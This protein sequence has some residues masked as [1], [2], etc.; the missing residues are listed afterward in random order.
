[1]RS[2]T[3]IG[4]RSRAR[5]LRRLSTVSRVLVVGA[6]ALTVTAVVSG[7]DGA[8]ARDHDADGHQHVTAG[9]D[10]R[11]L[12]ADPTL[13]RTG[14]TA[15]ADSLESGYGAGAVLDGNANSI[16]H[17]QYSGTIAPMPHTLTIDMHAMNTVSGLR[18]QPRLGA[19][20]GGSIG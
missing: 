5:G 15:V 20:R 11:N 8:G 2:P 3:A 13:P 18:Y 16:W 10:V 12:A 6:A 9:P 19:N 17:T 7:P 14:W 1:M 4:D